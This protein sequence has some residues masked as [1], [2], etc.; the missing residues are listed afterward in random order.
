[1]SALELE[2]D[3]LQRFEP[4]DPSGLRRDQRGEFLIGRRLGRLAGV[5]APVRSGPDRDT[6]LAR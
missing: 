5:M 6:N 3:Q 1:M 4:Y 2:H